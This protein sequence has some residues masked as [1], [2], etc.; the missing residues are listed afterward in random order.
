MSYWHRWKQA[1]EKIDEASSIMNDMEE[2]LNHW[3]SDI[4]SNGKPIPEKMEM[5]LQHI[6]LCNEA[7]DNARADIEKHMP[8]FDWLGGVT[9]LLMIVSKDNIKPD[10]SHEYFCTVCCKLRLSLGHKP[11]CCSICDSTKIIIGL[12]G[13]LNKGLLL[14]EHLP[15]ATK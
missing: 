13:T 9:H 6:N 4:K 15:T 2:Q 10:V 14:K 1:I 7:I 5:C 12:P 3:R 8:E 11:D